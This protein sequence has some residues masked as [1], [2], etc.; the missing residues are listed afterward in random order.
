M[1]WSN[2]MRL[3]E[4]LTRHRSD[5]DTG[6][7]TALPSESA[8]VR[9]RF[10]RPEAGSRGGHAPNCPARRAQALLQQKPTEAVLVWS[11]VSALNKVMG[12]FSKQ[13]LVTY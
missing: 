7:T 3:K 12:V 13:C 11:S 4:Q 8:A 5:H 6:V 9:L 1:T 10:P 2:H